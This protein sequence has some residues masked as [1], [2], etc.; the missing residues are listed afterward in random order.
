MTEELDP[1]IIELTGG[2][3]ST[4][5]EALD[6]WEHE[7]ELIRDLYANYDRY[8]IENAHLIKLLRLAKM[9]IDRMNT[10]AGLF[11]KDKSRQWVQ[12]FTD[13][14]KKLNKNIPQILDPGAASQEQPTE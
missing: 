11:L 1:R 13:E 4:L 14:F 10:D 12:D 9:T 5:E 8:R 6:Q 3:A 7:H 2:T